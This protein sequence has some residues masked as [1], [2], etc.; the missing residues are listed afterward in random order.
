MNRHALAW[1]D[2]ALDLSEQNRQLR[3]VL[4]D[5]VLAIAENREAWDFELLHFARSELERRFPEE[6]P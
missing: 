4:T 1:V 5:I 2:I 3:A 6:A